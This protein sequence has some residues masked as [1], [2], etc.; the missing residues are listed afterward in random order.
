MNDQI[1]EAVNKANLAPEK[2]SLSPDQIIYRQ[3][4]KMSNRQMSRRLRR[5][6]NT[7]THNIDAVWAI[8]LAEVFDNT[9]PMGR[10][11]PYLR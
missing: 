5:L 7:S 8:V 10:V 3:V 2:K 1:N 11:E 9:K 6:A 4:H